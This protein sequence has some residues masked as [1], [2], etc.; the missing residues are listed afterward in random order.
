M[1]V[2]QQTLP[3][4]RVRGPDL[5]V[6]VR[7]SNGVPFE[8]GLRRANEGNFVIASSA[9][10]SKALVGSEEWK[11]IKGVFACW[12]GTMTAYVEPGQKL[13]EQ[14][15]YIDP[16]TKVRWVFAVPEA[17]QDATNAILVAE[18]P[19][20]TLEVD[21]NNRVVHANAVDL[22]SAFPGKDGW[23]LA[24]S[25][26]GIPTGEQVAYSEQVRYLWRIAKR[27]GPVARGYDD[28]FD[29]RQ[30]VGL[31]TRPSGGYGVAVEAADANVAT[32]T[33]RPLSDRQID[34]SICGPQNEMVL[35]E[36]QSGGG[37]PLET[38]TPGSHIQLKLTRENS[39]TLI[40]SGTL[41][42]LDAAVRL[43]EQL[44]Q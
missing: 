28:F 30:G 41:E 23:Y 36:G 7:R 19:D 38:A 26:H 32:A 17:H 35:S 14:V 21:G 16:K 12:S 9:R 8:E 22:V 43:L 6:L 5:A 29:D 1:S 15:E 13:G 2:V 27:V 25:K 24:D 44:E 34:A 3:R 42:Q 20:Y 33:L 37:T 40:V 10:L 39:G 18:H 11:G 4:E 31:D